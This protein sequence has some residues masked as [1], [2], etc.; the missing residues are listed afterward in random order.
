MS[1]GFGLIKKVVEDDIPLT[2]LIEQGIDETYFKGAEKSAFEFLRNHRSKYGVYPEK[3]TIAIESGA[4]QAFDNLPNEPLGY[5]IPQIRERRQHD[6]MSKGVSNV[7]ENLKQNQVKEALRELQELYNKVTH[8]ESSYAV[9]DIQALE[10][11]ALNRHD[12]IQRTPGIAGVPYGFPS[13]DKITQGKQPGDLNVYVGVTG[14]CKSYIC[15]RSALGAY[16][17]GYSVLFISPE[18]PE[19]QVGRRLLALQSLFREQDIRKGRLSYYA[20]QKARNIINQ[21]IIVDDEKQDNFFRILPSGMFGDVNQVISITNEYRPHLLVVDG[22]YLL[23]DYQQKGAQNWAEAESILYKL[24]NLALS[25]GLAVDATTQYNRSQP[26]K[27]QGSR[28]TQATEQIA[29]NFYSIEFLNEE[30]REINRPQQT[31]VLKSKKTREGDSFSVRLELDFEK[32]TIDEGHLLSS[33][34]AIEEE[35]E[36]TDYSAENFIE[37]I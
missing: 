31:R 11:E 26:G 7:S 36:D 5:W 10:E 32:M 22:F 15:L 16:L 28:S 19:Q 4:A 9:Q 34:E 27:L 17:Q 1:I 29:S 25:S 6:L 12:Q 3:Q 20:V 23:R 14:A 24:K 18:M 37:T 21:P 30:D 33:A 8:T 13:I 35:A 2:D